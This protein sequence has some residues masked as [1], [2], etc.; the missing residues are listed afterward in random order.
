MDSEGSRR[1]IQ[2]AVQAGGAA[3]RERGVSDEECE[4]QSQRAVEL[5]LG[6]F[7]QTGY[8]GPRWTRE[9][10]RLLGKEADAVVAAK[11]GRSVDAVRVMRQRLHIPNPAARPGAYGSPGW[12]AKEDDFV[13]RL[14][15]GGAARRTGRTLQAVYDRR[16][17]L[18]LKQ[19]LGQRSTQRLSGRRRR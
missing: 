13:R 12:S 3:R 14:S 17:L 9:Q 18:G 8:H 4:E 19:S 16:S 7:L 2:A 5:N 15:P 10:L 11:V 6:R 1:L